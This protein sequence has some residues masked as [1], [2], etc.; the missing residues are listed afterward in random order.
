MSEQPSDWVSYLKKSHLFSTLADEELLAIAKRM[1]ILSLPKGAILFKRGD[2]G[3]AFYVIHSGRLQ[4]IDESKTPPAK[5]L[6]YLGRSE[7][8]GEMALLTGEPR[9]IT[10]R[11]DTMSELLVLYKKDFERLLQ[12]KPTIGVHLSRVLSSRLASAGQSV[13]STNEGEIHALMGTLGLED[14]ALLVLNLALSLV[15]Q[16]RRK[17]ALIEIADEPGWLATSLGLT[18]VPATEALLNREDLHNPAVLHKLGASHPSGL[19]V[20]SLPT[21]LFRGE[22]G[23]SLPILF[24]TLREAF[25]HVLVRLPVPSS[26]F[27]ASHKRP[28]SVTTDEIKGEYSSFVQ[29]LL[30]DANRIIVAVG[31]AS[32]SPDQLPAL[33]ASA[34]SEP[35][36]IRRVWIGTDGREAPTDFKPDFKIPWRADFSSEFERTRSVYLIQKAPLS[37]RMVDRLARFVGRLRIGIAMGSGAAYGYS[38]IGILKVLEREGIYPDVI[39]GTSMGALVGSFYAS[40]KSPKELGEIALTITKAKLWSMADFTLPRSGVLVGRGLIAFL[41]SVIGDVTFDQLPTPFACV[42]TDIRNGQEVILKEGSV[43]EAVRASLSLPFF[44]QPYYQDGRYLVDGGLVNPVP[45]SVIVNLGA[46]I[47]ISVN[48]TTKPSEKRIPRVIGWRRQLPADLRGPGVIEILIKTIYTMQHEIAQARS[49]VAHVVLEPDVS[50]FTWTEFHRSAEILKSGESCAEEA[51]PKI[52]A[53]LPF[54]TA[55]CKIPPV[56]G[57]RKSFYS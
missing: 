38:L 34:V 8:L 52:K 42:A 7:S 45:T 54:Y 10:A 36:K 25:D 50:E 13:P 40:G 41:K 21:Q 23:E 17:I 37:Q 9:T 27:S 44:F 4:V 28:E 3:D 5:I 43:A 14:E 2:P 49:E 6:A 24:S 47:L 33:I 22:L 11:A 15:E 19:E 31:P 46:D 20:I 1:V 57:H 35:Q 56:G 55:A 32:K 16:T 48:L 18:P 29:P 26:L 12:K 30:E 51:L 39:S 53:L